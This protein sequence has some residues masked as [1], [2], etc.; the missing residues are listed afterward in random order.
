MKSLLFS[1][2][3]LVI[4]ITQGNLYAGEPTVSNV[5]AIQRVGTEIVEITYDLSETEGLPCWVFVLVDRDGLDTWAIPVYSLVGDVGPDVTPS[6]GKYIEWDAGSDYDHAYSPGTVVKV[7]AHSLVNGVPED[8]ILVPAGEFIMGSSVVGGESIPE[9]AVYLDAYWIDKYEV[10]NHEY[11]RFCDTTGRVY[12]TDPGFA[13]LPNYF[14]DYPDYPVIRV[15]WYDAH[16]Y[17]AWSGK[18]LPTEAEWERAA[19]GNTDNRLWPWGDTFDPQRANTNQA[20]DG[21]TFTCPVNSFSN[22]VSPTGCFSMAGNIWE[23]VSDWIDSDYYSSSP[24]ANPQGPVTGGAKV[25]RGGSYGHSAAEAG[26]AYR[27]SYHSP[28][29]VRDYLGFRC[30]R[31]P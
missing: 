18:R 1:S 2:I 24:Y 20:G 30:A 25:F 5:S 19:K 3:L 26:C 27:H 4:L 16:D 17:A 31:T 22:G 8:M 15:T 13:D 12:P 29:T 23:W 7:V 21:W 14:L 28:E 10:T 6:S 9:H 11:K